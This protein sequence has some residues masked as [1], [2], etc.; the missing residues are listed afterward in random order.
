LN[1]QL[2]VAQKKHRKAVL[3]YFFLKIGSS[4]EERKAPKI[5][6]K[7]ATKYFVPGISRKTTSERAVATKG[8]A[9][10]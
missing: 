5:I 6:S 8:V 1:K 2:A 3:F 10:E 7:S 4:L 9:A